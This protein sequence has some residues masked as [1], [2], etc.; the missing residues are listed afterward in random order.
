MN[1]HRQHRSLARFRYFPSRNKPSFPLH[2]AA[3]IL[4]QG[5]R[6]PVFVVRTRA[7][8]PMPTTHL[9]LRTS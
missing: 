3:W 1:L 4:H 5:C 9:R 8:L 7:I 6:F 2:V